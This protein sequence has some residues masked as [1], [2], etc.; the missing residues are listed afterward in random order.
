MFVL[1]GEP[2]ENKIIDSET[3][4]SE[5]NSLSSVMTKMTPQMDQA[6]SP[7]RFDKYGKMNYLYII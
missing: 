7:N 4:T 6:L 5:L 3:Y 2:N 1:L